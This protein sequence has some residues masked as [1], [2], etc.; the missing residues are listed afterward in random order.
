ML[1]Q[2]SITFAEMFYRELLNGNSVKSA[3]DTAQV[4]LAETSC[5]SIGYQAIGISSK[6]IDRVPNHPPVLL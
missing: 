6:P 4:G 1:D 5:C 3:F 2:A